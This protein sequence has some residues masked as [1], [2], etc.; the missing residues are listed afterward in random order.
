MAGKGG[1]GKKKK[2]FWF[3][4]WTDPVKTKD[5]GHWVGR[6]TSIPPP[7]KAAQRAMLLRYIEENG[8]QG[9]INPDAYS[10]GKNKPKR[11]A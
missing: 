3:E 7:G 1:N 11:T 10:F 8:L 2:K 9:I 5:K 6:S 4:Q